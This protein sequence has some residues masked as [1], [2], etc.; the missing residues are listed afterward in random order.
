MG[1]IFAPFVLPSWNEFNIIEQWPRGYG[2]GFPISGPLVQNHLGL[3]GGLSLS[4][5]GDSSNEYHELLWIFQ[6]KLS[7]HCDSAV[8]G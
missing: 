6:S 1:L 4:S 8:M 3:T 7:C 2:T 5:P